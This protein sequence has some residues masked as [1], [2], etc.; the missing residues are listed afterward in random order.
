MKKGLVLE[1]GAMRGLFSAGI[2]DVLMENNITFDGAIGVS[3]GACFGCNF[4]SKQIGRVLRYNLKYCRDK[5]YCSFYSLIT[6]GNLYGADFCYRQIPEKLDIFDVKAFNDNQM[7]FYSVSS[8]V[9]TGKPV[10]TL[11]DTSQK[12]Y[13]EWIRASASLP[14]VSKIVE[15]DEKKLLD[16]GLTDSIPLKQ[17]QKMGYDKN[18]VILTQPENYIK[19]PN[20]AMPL[21][22][23]SLKKYPKIIEAINN[24]HL[25]YN[26]TT[27]YVKDEAKKGNVFIL[28]PDTPLPVKRIEKD[29]ENLKLAYNEGRKV[30]LKNLS[31]IKEFLSQR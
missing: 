8:D 6:T 10:Y 22:R 24:R 11:M 31:A 21:I 4:K 13:F 17:F 2:M 20:K 12:N 16:G 30:A 19:K 1:G 9:E 18:V 26:E 25:M 5:R 23:L 28:C 14:L 29:P 15:I 7:E 27:Q 3:A